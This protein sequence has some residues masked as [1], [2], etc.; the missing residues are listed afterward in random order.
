MQSNTTLEKLSCALEPGRAPN[1][2]C[3]PYMPMAATDSWEVEPEEQGLPLS[4]YLWVFR[5]HRWKIAAFVLISAISTL[6][7]SARLVPIYE[8]TAT[9]DVDRRVPTGIIG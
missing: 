4:H 9:V 8:S 7:V 3:M 1:G 6:I 2:G 5:R